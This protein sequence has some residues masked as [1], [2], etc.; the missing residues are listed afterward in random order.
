M[1]RKAIQLANKT[2]V[3]SLPAKWVKE[4]GVKKGDEIEVEEREGKIIVSIQ[5]EPEEIKKIINLDDY[6]IMQ[7]RVILSQY[8]RGVDELEIKFSKPHQIKEK[9]V[10]K[11]IGFEIIKQTPNSIT[12]KDLSGFSN[13]DISQIIKRIFLIIES[14][15]FELLESIEKNQ[16]NLEHIIEIDKETNK[17]AYY[18]IRILSKQGFGRSKEILYSIIL[19]LESIGDKY[20]EIARKITENKIK[21]TKKDLKNIKITNEFFILFKNLFFDVKNEKLIKWAEFY[22]ANKDNLIINSKRKEQNI[23]LN[24]HL[25]E[26][27]GNILMMNN[28]LLMTI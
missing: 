10:N 15:G 20:R 28:N 8:L 16:K 7:N 9:I 22:E 24:T 4:R 19:C 21:L 11:L 17:M 13:Q 5:K 14:M 26:I 27:N 18:A 1:K 23:S 2:L 6:G 25:T 3:I 12:F